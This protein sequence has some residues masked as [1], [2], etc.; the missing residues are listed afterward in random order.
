LPTED[1]ER[2]VVLYR[3]ALPDNF[4]QITFSILRRYFFA[5]AAGLPFALFPGPASDGVIVGRH[6]GS[7]AFGI[8]GGW[9]IGRPRNDYQDVMVA[10]SG[11]TASFHNRGKVSS[12]FRKVCQHHV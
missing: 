3:Q 8:V 7:C 2:F 1:A 12:E 9:N 11:D 4:H 5:E 10:G 6:L